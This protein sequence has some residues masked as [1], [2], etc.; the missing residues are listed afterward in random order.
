[1]HQEPY[2]SGTHVGDDDAGLLEFD[3][4]VAFPRRRPYRMWRNV[5]RALPVVLLTTLLLAVAGRPDLA[6]LFRRSVANRH[7]PITIVCN[8][9][10]AV[11]HVDR[12][13]TAAPCIQ[14]VTDTLAMAR[15]SVDAGKHMLM[16]TAEGFSPY[17][18]YIVAHPDTP[19]LYL[20]QF[21]LTPH[22]SAKLLDAANAYFARAYAQDVVF[23]ATLW[24]M[25][26]LRQPP[27]VPFLVIRDRFE[28]VS[29]DSYEPFYTQTTYQRP[30]IPEQG[31]IG[32]AVVVV[33]H[34]TIYD[35]C[36]TT[37]LLERRAP[38]LYATRASVTFSARPGSQD[39]TVMKP[40]ALSPTANIYT[41]PDRAAS[42]LTPAGL[43]DL[44]ARTELARQLGSQSTLAGVV[45]ITPL[46]SASNWAD[47]AVVTLASDT[48]RSPHVTDAQ[49]DAIWLHVGGQL[50]ALTPAAQQLT[51]DAP[52][53]VPS[54]GVNDLR[55]SVANQPSRI[56]GGE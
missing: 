6:L 34:V 51:P 37:P 48:L 47:G 9:P 30:V 24:R 10:W 3:E 11:V 21:T 31:T 19:G 22:G 28:A 33:N 15:L 42:P 12:Q 38:V 16:A 20:T 53:I 44:A 23:P 14:D 25:L 40:Y 49:L 7:I 52:A 1:M 8:V 27:S 56:C 36:G 13:E 54:V 41:T 55:A 5:W 45:T 43:V 29:L 50:L 2:D 18:I 4:G 32:I 26:G 46:V 17:P 35:D 39:W